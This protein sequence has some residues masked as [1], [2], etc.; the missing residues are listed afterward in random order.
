MFLF[1][2]GKVEVGRSIICPV[3]S[4]L[5]AARGLKS[6]DFS[7]LRPLSGVPV[8]LVARGLAVLV[9][10]AAGLTPRAMAALSQAVSLDSWNSELRPFWLG[11][12]V[13][14]STGYP[15]SQVGLG[16]ARV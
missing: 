12:A 11:L 4:S 9:P 7:I 8:P 1:R 16:A 13:L 15:R 3:A 5:N 10:G 6:R 2:D 14:G